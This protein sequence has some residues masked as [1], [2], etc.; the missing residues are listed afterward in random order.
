MTPD[1]RAYLSSF[2]ENLTQRQPEPVFGRDAEIEQVLQALASPL[3]NRA[4]VIGPPRVGKS[5]VLTAVA[6]AIG[7]GACPPALIG[8]E[9]WRFR[10]NNLPGLT[11]AHGWQEPL[12]RF[13]QAWALEP[14]VILLIDDLTS[15]AWLG[16]MRNGDET[17]NLAQALLAGLTRGPGLCLAEANERPWQQ[18]AEWY[19]AYPAMF[20]PVRVVEPPA[21][22][23]KAIIEQAA[24]AL[25]EGQHATITAG[26]VDQALHLSRRF[27][28]T[29]AQ[30]GK[31]LDVLKDALATQAGPEPTLT[32]ADVIRSFAARTGL[33]KML[34]DESEAFDEEK[35]AA[36]FR[37]RVLAQ[38]QAVE[39]V[40]QMLSLLRARINNPL[41][42]MG[43]FFFLGPTG[44]GKTELA[45]ALADYLFGSQERLVRFNMGDYQSPH[46]AQELFGLPY[47]DELMRRR[48]TFTNRMA[49]QAFNVIVLDEFEKAHPAIYFRFLQLFDEGLLIN[50]AD[51]EINLRNSIIIVTSNFGAQLV[52]KGQIGFAGHETPEARERRVIAETER[53]F[54]PE[55]INRM[56]AV[57]IFHP[58]TRTVMADI[59]R[60]EISDLFARDGLL[61][62]GVEVD[63]ADSVIE[64]VVEIGYDP[65]YGARYLKRQ[66]EKTVA[67]PLSRELNRL[68]RGTTGGGLRLFL[69][70]GRVQAAYLAAQAAPI[71]ATSTPPGAPTLA[72]MRAAL[73]VLT[74]R[75]EA[76][77]ETFGLPE[78][79]LERDAV[80]AEMTDVG[81]WNDPAAARRR[82]DA[83]QRASAVIDQLTE[84]R[85]GLER[86]Q[87]SLG[88]GSPRADGA[89]RAFTFLS[90]E[91]PRVEFTSYLSGPHDAGGAY[92]RITVKSKATGAQRWAAELARMYLGWGK[93]RGLTASVLGEDLAPTG[94]Q[95]SLTLALSGFGVFGLLRGEAGVHKLVQQVKVSGREML[96][97]FSA[98]V[99]VLPEISED[100]LPTLAGMS[101]EGRPISRAGLL[102]GR[103]TAQGSAHLDSGGGLT[104]A[105]DL[106]ADDLAVE[107]AR[108]LRIERWLAENPLDAAEPTAPAGLVRTYTRNTRD[109][110]VQDHRTGRR[111]IKL[112]QV[113][114]GEIQEFLDAALRA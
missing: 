58:L 59:A 7:R 96:Q 27:D 66:I 29:R 70:G 73:P 107:A 110:G 50:A 104:L 112:N 80:L 90:T 74:A 114:A 19:P 79:V 85:R 82:L 18:F 102:I 87:Q 11:Q 61:R 106:P 62:R 24:A 34:L 86:L 98:E 63:I 51:E 52:E 3:K 47:A 103:L 55:F 5:S 67:Y 31:S 16:L 17:V 40:L 99:A 76:L 71:P 84:L 95:V 41:R 42:P 21:V 113:L 28:P 10:P 35:V 39:S 111:S 43:V 77:E 14:G 20:L 89:L 1:F 38:E 108:L 97:R 12:E 57:C 53:N 64:H 93:G 91:L 54:T 46:Q 92:L 2:A 23:Y 49:G 105:G 68:P 48:G 25:A 32:E 8:R 13:L 6:G 15:A 75:L 9:V 65:H 56:D 109:K 94:R 60:R 22:A 37:G 33:P 72:E 36:F 88:S 100:D 83:Y 26:A 69:K 78:Q 30:P 44:V 45:R 101:T 4:I 81:F